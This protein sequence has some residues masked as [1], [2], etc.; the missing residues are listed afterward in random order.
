MAKENAMFP[1]SMLRERVVWSSCVVILLFQGCALVYSF[2]VPIYF[3][4]SRNAAPVWSGLYN[5]PGIGSQMIVAGAS[6]A[7]GKSY[8]DRRCPD[9]MLTTTTVGRWGYYLPWSVASAVLVSLGSFLMS[10]LNQYSSAPQWIGYQVIAGIGRGCGA[11]MV[12][13]ANL[14]YLFTSIPY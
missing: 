14:V 8:L 13:H 5:S 1:Y 4:A 9:I 2:F 11:T 10:T 12:S 6:S 7:L 3:Q